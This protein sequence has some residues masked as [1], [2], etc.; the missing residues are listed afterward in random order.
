MLSQLSAYITTFRRYH[1]KYLQQ[2]VYGK[3]SIGPT[4]SV[5]LMDSSLICSGSVLCS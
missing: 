1:N 4:N 2:K 5:K 3:E